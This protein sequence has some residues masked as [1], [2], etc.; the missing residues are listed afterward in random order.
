[1]ALGCAMG[2]AGALLLKTQFLFGDLVC[3]AGMVLAVGYSSYLAADAAGLSGIVSIIF[4]SMVG[5]GCART[6]RVKKGFRDTG[7]FF[8]FFFK[9]TDISVENKRPAPFV[10][11]G[12]LFTKLDQCDRQ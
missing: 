3:E 12:R 4:C 1:M 9:A 11:P 5:S 7:P 2:G 6:G 10:V 8:F